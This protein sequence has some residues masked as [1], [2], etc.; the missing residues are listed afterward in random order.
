MVTVKDV[1]D[2]IDTI[3]PFSG[4]LDFDNSGFLVGDPDRTVKNIAVSLDITSETIAG[5]REC[6]ADLMVSHHPV[7]YKAKKNIL[8][9]DPVYE[10]ISSGISAICAH[11]SLDCAVGGVNDVLAEIFGLEKVEA[12]PTNELPTPMIRV[13]FLPEPLTPYELAATAAE[14]LGSRLRWCDG[15]K[16]IETVAVCGGSGG[17]LV[18]DMIEL[19]I[20]ALITGD[21]G[22]HNFLDAEENGLTLI[23]AGHF[24]T[25]NPVVPVLAEKLR[26]R[27]P[28]VTVAVLTQT[29]QEKRL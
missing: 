28:D 14:K 26:S 8:K 12:L 4:Q 6:Q 3:A 19:Q 23:A 2:Y 5:A 24:E 15:G 17:S 1:Y 27:F 13:G 7:I 22:Y 29:V 20:D 18:N 16:P 10:L 25:E 21:A 11:T 9:G